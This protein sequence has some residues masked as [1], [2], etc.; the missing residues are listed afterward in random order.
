CQSCDRSLRISIIGYSIF[1]VDGELPPCT[2]DDVLSKCPVDP[3][4]ASRSEPIREDQQQDPDLAR[5]IALSLSKG[6][7]V[8]FDEDEEMK[9]ALETSRR[10]LDENDHSLQQ[11]IRESMKEATSQMNDEDEEMDR[12]LQRA[13]QMSLEDS[14]YDAGVGTSGFCAATRAREQPAVVRQA[15]CITNTKQCEQS[16]S[17]VNVEG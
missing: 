6:G 8:P 1:V 4:L 12:Q 16:V 11:A 17:S 13:L 14:A 15:D 3:A 5:A 9:R 2:A 7:D 10:L